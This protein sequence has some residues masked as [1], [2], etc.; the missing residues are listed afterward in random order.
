MNNSE[1]I[2]LEDIKPQICIIEDEAD[3]ANLLK[4]HLVPQGYD[5]KIYL[6]AEE[7]FANIE[8]NF[9]GLYLIDWNLPGE[10][11]ISIVSKIRQ[12][13][14]FSPIFMVSGYAR[15]EDIVTGLNAGA[16]DYITKPFSLDELSVKIKNASRKFKRLLSEVNTDEIK[17]L[18]EANSYI[19]DNTTV[20]LTKREFLIFECLYKHVLEPVNRESLLK[21]FA[22]EEDMTIRNIDVHIFSLRKKIKATNLLIETLW[23][24]GY[25]LVV[26]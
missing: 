6:S 23:G 22:Q 3:I 19:K 15:N 18:S 20:S 5:V 2:V 26:C 1:A 13:D 12:K 25:K 10:L 7:F 11:G 4:D 8:P 16:D 21:C 9:K 14:H 24:K 17:L